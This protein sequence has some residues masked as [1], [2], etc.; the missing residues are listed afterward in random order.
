MLWL[1]TLSNTGDPVNNCLMWNNYMYIFAVWITI[2]ETIRKLY[3]ENFTLY[4]KLVFRCFIHFAG[5]FFN[6]H[7]PV[8]CCSFI[9]DINTFASPISK[10]YLFHDGNGNIIKSAY[11]FHHCIVY[12]ISFASIIIIAITSF[13]NKLYFVNGCEIKYVERC[14]LCD[15]R[16]PECCKRVISAGRRISL[17]TDCKDLYFKRWKMKDER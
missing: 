11:G 12:N 16:L 5:I 2:L 10:I 3:N 9:F 17:P 7:I 14:V 15:E 6:I 4:F 13:L 1:V 8:V